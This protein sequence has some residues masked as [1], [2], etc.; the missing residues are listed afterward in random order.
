MRS[1]GLD[2]QSVEV[3]KREQSGREREGKRD[4]TEKVREGGM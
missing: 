4:R 2:I 3:R 1:K